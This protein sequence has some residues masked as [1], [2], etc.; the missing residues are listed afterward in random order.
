MYERNA[1][2]HAGVL[3]GKE[4]GMIPRTIRISALLALLALSATVLWYQSSDSEPAPLQEAPLPG[5]PGL[6]SVSAPI[7]RTSALATQAISTASLSQAVDALVATRDPRKVYAAYKLLADC[8]SFNRDGDRLI[9]DQEDAAHW[10][11]DGTL[12][13]F[14]S[15]TDAEKRHDA[16][17]CG[18]MTERMRQSRIDYLAFAAQNGVPGAAIEQ[19]SEGP[20]GDRSALAT[21]PD[22]PLVREWKMRVHDQMARAADNE[23]D[24]AVLSYLSATRMMGNEVFDKD[25]ALAYRYGVAMSLIYRDLNGPDNIMAKQ[26][27]PE[28]SLMQAAGA[29]LTMQERSAQLAEAQRI[30]DIARARRQRE[31]GVAAQTPAMPLG[32]AL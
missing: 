23:A 4:A 31:T 18:T 29:S 6:A 32:N 8:A 1:R 5:Q 19:A 24:L 3:H 12:P 21:R 25:P 7:R 10:N 28:G 17:F 30:A 20:F 9:F 16:V 27:S 22:D 13:G 2:R 11:N 26:Y 14:R 15:M